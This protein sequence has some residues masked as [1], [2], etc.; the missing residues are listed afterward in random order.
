MINRC[1]IL[2]LSIA[3]LASCA[4][5]PTPLGNPTHPYPPAAEP[6]VGDIIHLPTGILV[7]Y[8]TLLDN[9]TSYRVVFVG[10]THDNPASH[11]LQQDILQALQQ[12]S[13]GQITVAMEMFTP[14]QQPILDLW[15][16]GQLTEKEFLKQVDWNNTW[17]I[18]FAFYRPILTY[19]RDQQI[20]ILALNA[21]N[22]LKQ[23]VSR[24]P[25]ALLSTEDQRKLPA[26]DEHDPYQRAMAEAV[27]SDHKMGPDM[28][29]GFLRVQT[30]WDESMAENLANYLKKEPQSRQVMVMAGGNHIRYGYG[31]PR[32]MFRRLPISYVLV[33]SEE[34]DIPEHKRAQLMNINEPSYLM[35]PYEYVLYTRYED[36][37]TPG[38]KMGITLET[39]S[40]GVMVKKVMPDSA[41]EQAG[42]KEED[43]LVQLDGETL[44]DVFDLTYALQQ[45]EIGDSS[46]IVLKR[47]VDVLKVT[48]VF[49]AQTQQAKQQ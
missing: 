44:N 21:E 8:Q 18:N 34:I 7:S 36:L 35:I 28:R 15:S 45:K 25:F 22:D 3:V 23:K 32:R 33:G 46:L 19:C 42:L 39:T 4:P 40:K 41:A 24:I 1:L 2:L 10:E 20:K 11:R 9:V 49:C 17:R 5:Q 6:Q 14:S 27:F 37:V 31:I 38:V 48:I 16:T 30:L 13:P 26:L 29:E 12:R 47:G 43:I